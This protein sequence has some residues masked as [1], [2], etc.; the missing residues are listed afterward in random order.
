MRALFVLFT[1]AISN[2]VRA[3]PTVDTLFVFYDIF[4]TSKHDL[5]EE[6][7]KRSP[8]KKNGQTFHGHT[9]WYVKWNFNWKRTNGSCSITKV[10][11]TVSITYTLPQIAR[12]HA[13]AQPVRQ[14]FENYYLSLFKHEENHM[15]SGLYAAREIEIALLNIDALNCDELDASVNASANK[16]IS[17]Y[18]ERDTE[19]DKKTN[20]GKTEGV[21]ISRF[22]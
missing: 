14:S 19:Y 18:N 10:N 11:T 8:V 12:N 16:I 4:P 3:N 2:I 13:V 21:D 1:L 17:K 7:Y 22:I 5:P 20:H 15:A 9:Q 6:M